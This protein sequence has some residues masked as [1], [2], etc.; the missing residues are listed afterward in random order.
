VNTPPTDSP[1]W[2]QVYAPQ[3]GGWIWALVPPAQEPGGEGG[4]SPSP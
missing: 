4:E 2:Q 1:Y 3:A